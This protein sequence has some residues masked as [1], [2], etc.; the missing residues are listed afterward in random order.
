MVTLYHFASLNFADTCTHSHY[1]L[2]NWAYF[3]GL[4]FAVRQSSA[5]TTKIGPLE[6]FPLYSSINIGEKWEHRYKTTQAGLPRLSQSER[7]GNCFQSYLFFRS[8]ST[9]VLT[10]ERSKNVARLS[11]PLDSSCTCLQWVVW[12]IITWYKL[13]E[14]ENK[15]MKT[16]YRALLILI[17]NK[18]SKKSLSGV[19]TIV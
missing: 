15:N 3:A 19:C 9:K 8:S 12:P 18:H 13:E 4:I 10:F 16:Q 11:G 5:K 17:V 1:V 6:N 14:R 2:Y 7:Q